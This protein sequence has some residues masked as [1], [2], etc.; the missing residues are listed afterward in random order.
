MT[1]RGSTR[2]PLAAIFLLFVVDAM[3]V[4]LMF[5][6]MPDLIREV[7]GQS[8]SNA[9][10]WGGVM[11]T[12]FAVMQFVCAPAIGALSDR[13]GRRPILLISLAVMLADYLILA[14]AGSIWLL[15]LLRLISGVTAAN[16]AVGNAY[17]ADITPPEKRAANFG[18]F[19]AGFG[20]GFVIGPILGGMLAEYGTRAPFLAAAALTAANLA[21]VALVLPETVKNRRFA[22]PRWAEINP[23]SAFTRLARLPGLR[24]LLVIVLTNEIAV[25]VYP[26]IWAY[27]TLEVFA[28]STT[29]IGVSLSLFG[30]CM[31]VVQAGVIRLYLRALGERGTLILGLVLN[32]AVFSVMTVTTSAT[33][34]MLLIPVS[35]L[36]A[37]ILPPVKAMMSRQIPDDMQGELLGVVSST[38][39]V[40]AIFGPLIATASF[41]AFTV[42]EAPL[43]LPG[44]PF[45]IAAALLTG[46]L[47]MVLTARNMR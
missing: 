31:A 41:R 45:G 33:L 8:L 35:A 10:L 18:L 6:V 29:Q 44:I 39:S 46:S 3:G 12:S 17:I 27:Y 9:A 20:I 2:L 15:L 7:T 47:V 38:S 42:P 5:P 1:A 19:G 22:L 28:W 23:L 13:W 26:A 37:V 16:Y 24:G 25:V 34:V 21:F 32:I 11:A 43:Y 30:V 14:V 40:G 4:G 36:G